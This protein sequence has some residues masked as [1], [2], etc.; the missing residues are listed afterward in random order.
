[1]QHP[2]IRPRFELFVDLTAEQTLRR[3]EARIEASETIRGWVS[4]PYA[5]LRV[6]ERDRFT[7]SPRMALYAEDAPGG[8]HLLCRL[9]PEP[10]VWTA[11]LALWAVV[12][13]AAIGVVM[14]G[15]SQWVV[16]GMP[17]VMVVGLPVVAIAAGLLYLVAVVGQRSGAAQ[18]WLLRRELQAALDGH[19]PRVVEDAIDDLPRARGFR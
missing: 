9:Q 12:V 15:V 18:M 16:S 10:D 11:Y 3:V 8:T 14:Y 7:W 6:P 17:W 5:E 1:V 13:V 19:G 2:S 4:P